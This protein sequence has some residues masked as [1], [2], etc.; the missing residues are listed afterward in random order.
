MIH[1]KHW[2][3]IP[4]PAVVVTPEPIAVAWLVIGAS[5]PEAAQVTV[6]AVTLA[7]LSKAQQTCT[8]VPTGIVTLAWTT[9]LVPAA[10]AVSEPTRPRSVIAMAHPLSGVGRMAYASAEVMAAEAKDRVSPMAIVFGAASAPHSTRFGV[11]VLSQ[12]S[13]AFTVSTRG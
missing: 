2:C 4:A 3:Q 10:L 13:I 5:P 6:G 1:R 7:M 12:I 9:R 8:S 11:P